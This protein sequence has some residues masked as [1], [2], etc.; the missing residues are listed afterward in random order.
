MVGL[1]CLHCWGMKID[2]TTGNIFIGEILFSKQSTISDLI[3][4]KQLYNISNVVDNGDYQMYWIRYV[5]DESGT[6]NILCNYYKNDVTT[7]GVS[8]HS[9]GLDLD[10]F[11]K[12]YLENTKLK[13]KSLLNELIGGDG[14][15]GVWGE[16]QYSFDERSYTV[17]IFIS[18]KFPI[19]K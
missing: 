16:I 6:F 19:S 9:K 10:D 17:E 3:S 11:I 5:K 15:E 12:H 4:Y 18:Y 14:Y 2:K 7:V 8:F 1:V 13:T